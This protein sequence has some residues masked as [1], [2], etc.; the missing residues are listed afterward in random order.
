MTVSKLQPYNQ[1]NK[2][3]RIS[4]PVSVQVGQGLLL[5]YSFRGFKDFAGLVMRTST[6]SHHCGAPSR[7]RERLT[8]VSVTELIQRFQLFS[9]ALIG[10]FRIYGDKR[11]E[12][13]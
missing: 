8:Q 12:W 9:A 4:D 5:F 10:P 13:E 6:A 1:G 7:C 11:P 3:S 2:T